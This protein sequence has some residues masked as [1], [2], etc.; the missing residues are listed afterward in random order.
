M[1]L[2]TST[3]HFLLAVAVSVLLI[4]ITASAQVPPTPKPYP[5]PPATSKQKEKEKEKMPKF[6]T[7]GEFPTGVEWGTGTTSE[8]SIAVDAKVSITMCVTQGSVTV[9]GWKRDEIRA[10]VS[11][12]SKF[13]FRVLQKSMKEDGKPVLL[14]LVGIK[15]L[16]GGAVTMVD[17]IAGSEIQLD[18]PENAA[19]SLRGRETET[20]VDTLRKIVVTNV[21]GDISIRNVAQ[22]VTAKTGQGDI[23][24]ENSQG[25]MYLESSSGNV[26]A[27]AVEPAEVGD[28]FRA[29]TN[30]GAISLQK[31]GYRLADITSISGTVLFTGRLLMGGSF[32]FNTT[33]GAI[34][35]AI[36]Q[37]SSCRITATYGFGNFNSELPIKLLTEDN[38]PGP[39][40]TVNA[41][42]GSGDS[43]LRLTTNSGAIQIRKLQP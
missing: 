32:S 35:L 1:K 14:S 40:K 19:L 28:A 16:P 34:R 18:V 8:R 43:T 27:F 3:T 20:S 25:A 12:G 7:P 23:T 30:S 6:P 33:N 11:E 4:A 21:G 2:I 39:V 24:V 37:D 17:C 22:G 36:P 9:N 31:I 15:T 29:K 38:R 5:E 10:F 26:V 13:G 42:M 41:V